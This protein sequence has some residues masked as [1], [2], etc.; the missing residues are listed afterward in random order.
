MK[1]NI[2]KKPWWNETCRE[3]VKMRK[4]AFNKW[5][6]NTLTKKTNKI[7]KYQ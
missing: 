5:K 1:N 2:I 7:T 3:V 6:K 4:R